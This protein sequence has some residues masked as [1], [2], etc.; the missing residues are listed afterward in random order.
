MC[1]EEGSTTFVVDAKVEVGK[2]GVVLWEKQKWK[3]ST[4]CEI[5]IQMVKFPCRNKIKVVD[6]A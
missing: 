3:W 2:L 6:V 4:L 5:K 1:K